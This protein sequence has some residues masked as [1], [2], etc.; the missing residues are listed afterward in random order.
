EDP[1]LAVAPLADEAAERAGGDLVMADRG[2]HA[3]GA[4]ARLLPGDRGPFDDQADVADVDL[5][6][7][8][9]SDR[10]QMRP[11]LKRA[12][13]DAGRQ[14]ELVLRRLEDSQGD[15]WRRGGQVGGLLRAH[16]RRP[17]R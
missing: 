8:P 13:L 16:A 7:R 5:A 6:F 12:F 10:L 3:Q 11:I 4:D 9:L 17:D 2:A 15:R 1:R 14:G